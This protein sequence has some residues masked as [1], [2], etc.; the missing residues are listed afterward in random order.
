MEITLV[1]MNAVGMNAVGHECVGMGD[2]RTPRQ[3]CLGLG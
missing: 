2:G 1:G 3:D